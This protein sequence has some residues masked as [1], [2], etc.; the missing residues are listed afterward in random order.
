MCLRNK[1]QKKNNNKV[2][3][4]R[5]NKDQNFEELLIHGQKTPQI[6]CEFWLILRA[7]LGVAISQVRFSA[8]SVFA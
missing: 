3:C 7:K 6:Y 5:L 4:Q 1:G 2:A 8:F